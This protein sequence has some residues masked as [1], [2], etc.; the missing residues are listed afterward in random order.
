MYNY[1][2]NVAIENRPQLEDDYYFTEKLTDCFITGTVPIYYGCPHIGKLFDEK[3]IITF[4]TMEELHNILDNLS[5]EKYNSML[6]AIKYNFNRCLEICILT[7]DSIYDKF[8]RNIINK[9][10]IDDT[11]IQCIYNRSTSKQI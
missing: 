9:E 5:F 6:D 11:I 8:Y 7:N 4:S 2:F 3:G 10:D 1:A